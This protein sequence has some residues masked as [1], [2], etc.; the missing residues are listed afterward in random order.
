MKHPALR[1]TALFLLGLI[2]G[3]AVTGAALTRSCQE[4]VEEAIPH[5]LRAEERMRDVYR[6][7]ELLC[8]D[9]E[10]S[11]DLDGHFDIM[12]LEDLTSLGIH[13]GLLSSYEGYDNLSVLVSQLRALRYENVFAAIPREDRAALV[14]LLR[15]LQARGGKDPM[16]DHSVKGPTREEVEEVHR[17]LSAAQAAVGRE[18][19]ALPWEA[20]EAA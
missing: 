16:P 9:I 2:L 8:Q 18:A 7:L 3:G 15:G 12:F 11:M 14:E 17:I 10:L 5:E 13:C 20:E 6:D 19:N 4:R 1:L